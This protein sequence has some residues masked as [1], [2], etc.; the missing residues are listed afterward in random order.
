AGADR[1]DEDID[2]LSHQIEAIKSVTTSIKSVFEDD[3]AHTTETVSKNSDGMRSLWQEIGNNVQSCQ[4][5]L[6]KLFGLIQLIVGKESPK[7]LSKFDG[8]RRFLRKQAKEDEFGML[9][10]QLS[11]YHHSLQTLLTSVNM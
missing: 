11:D 10:Q 6:A 3:L 8:L 7:L 5:T 9:R 2:A 4:A 1:V